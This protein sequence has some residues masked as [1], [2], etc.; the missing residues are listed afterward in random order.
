MTSRHVLN[1]AISLLGAGGGS[2]SGLLIVAQPINVKVAA[3]GDRARH[4][5]RPADR[6]AP[7]MVLPAFSSVPLLPRRPPR[8]PRR[9]PLCAASPLR[10][11]PPYPRPVPTADGGTLMVLETPAR[12]TPT[13]TAVLLHDF[14][15]DHRLYTHLTPALQMRAPSVA[16]VAYD[17]RGFGRSSV[18]AARYCRLDD[19]RA[20]AGPR[21][22]PYHLVGAGRGGAIALQHALARP[23]ATASVALLSSAL[24]GHRWAP[25]AALD[26][27]EARLAAQRLVTAR[28]R[29]YFMEDPDERRDL[30]KWKQA[31]IGRSD[32]WRHVLR[33][34][35]K[36]VAR[37]LLEMARDYRGFH[38]F[39]EEQVEN[40]FFDDD[41][42]LLM[43]LG[44]VQ[45][46]VLV[47]AGEDDPPDFGEIAHEIWDGVPRKFGDAPGVVRGAGHF[48][49]AEAPEE[50][51]NIIALF[52]KA[53]EGGEV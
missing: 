31:F 49:A 39:Q 53:V 50:V 10:P 45:P 25:A 13:G 21:G 14:L 15:T 7:A 20:A 42:P 40:D 28:E 38:F 36:D 22:P 27:T 41:V 35:E 11:R 5:G 6:R 19:L 37:M 24:P 30:V 46:P 18:P 3:G 34:G 33:N 26:I 2:R 51:A 8:R 12:S 43:R 29:G 44:E 9:T 23:A 16:H 4:S 17:Q 47:L 52:W 48:S 32:A 1:V